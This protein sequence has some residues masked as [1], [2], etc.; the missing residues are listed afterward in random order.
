MHATAPAA[1]ALTMSLPRRTPPSQMIAVRPSVA[2]TTGATRENGAGDP[3]TWRPPWLDNATALTPRSA[4]ITASAVV[5][6]PL[7]TIGPFHTDWSHSTSDH[8][9]A[10]SNCVLM[11]SDTS[12]G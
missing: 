3:S 11:Y 5:W 12:T 7:I 6:I 2:S 1:T 8:D 10:G 9:S 4:A